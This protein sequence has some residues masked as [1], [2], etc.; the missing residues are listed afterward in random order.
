MNL[1]GEKIDFNAIT[2][3]C[4]VLDPKELLALLSQNKI[5]FWSWGAKNF[6]IDNK[7]NCRMFRMTVSGHHHKGHVYIFLNGMDLFDV[8]LTTNRGTIKTIQIDLY[9]DQLSEWIDKKIEKIPE[10]SS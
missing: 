5:M 4:R 7:N 9:F 6:T 1:I 8:Y 2:K 3:S 10:Y